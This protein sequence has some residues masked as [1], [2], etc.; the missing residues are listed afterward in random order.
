M[1]LDA[2]AA[3][4]LGI[5]PALRVCPRRR[6]MLPESTASAI[7][8]EE[9]LSRVGKNLARILV[10]SGQR[11]L[12]VIERLGMRGPPLLPGLRGLDNA[13]S[14]RLRDHTLGVWN[15]KLRHIAIAAETPRRWRILQEAFDLRRSWPNGD[16]AA[17]CSSAT[18]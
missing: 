9:A 11:P 4:H 8:W 1:F 10:R 7:P 15:A 13:R 18:P 17:A 6:D 2:A 16:A 14:W 3:A 12:G 5:L